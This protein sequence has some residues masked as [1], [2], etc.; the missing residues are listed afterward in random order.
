MVFYGFAVL[1][2]GL[3]CYFRVVSG[4]FLKIAPVFSFGLLFLFL[5]IFLLRPLNELTGV[6]K[7]HVFSKVF[8]GNAVPGRDSG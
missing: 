1:F 5:E 8:C 3:L 7:D 2:Y 6:W 4:C